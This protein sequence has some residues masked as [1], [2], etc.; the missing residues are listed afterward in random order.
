MTV[1]H[2][3]VVVVIVIVAPESAVDLSSC[4][5]V[6]VVVNSTVDLLS[7]R[8]SSKLVRLLTLD[9][10]TTPA[11]VFGSSLLLLGSI[12]VVNVTGTTF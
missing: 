12:V 10:N 11:G 3:L 6:V 7:L 9:S 8:E 5:V 1:L 4:D 2:S